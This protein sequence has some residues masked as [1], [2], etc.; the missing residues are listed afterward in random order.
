MPSGSIKEWIRNTALV[1]AI[2]LPLA[3]AA[4]Q[5]IVS[6]GGNLH[7]GPDRSYPVVAQLAPGTPATVM[8]CVSGYGWCDVVVPGGLR[9]WMFSGRLDYAYQGA[10]VPLVS[11][12]A[13]IGVPIVTFTL[14]TYWNNYYRDR[15]W[16]RDTRWWGG[17][18]PPPPAVGWRPPPPSAPRWQPRQPPAQWRPPQ[19]PGMVAPP[20]RP[21]AARPQSLERRPPPG[22]NRRQSERRDDQNG[23]R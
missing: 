10:P 21:P 18:R 14:G 1:A 5:A 9:G 16:Y 7:A 19:R 17:R 4:Q 13:A 12:G 2:A 11:I 23:N 22:S 3:A 8:G 20:A 6:G 15:P